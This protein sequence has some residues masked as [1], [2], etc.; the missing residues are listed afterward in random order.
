MAS[1]DSSKEVKASLKAAR[2]AI[3]QQE[4]KEALKHCKSVLKLDRTN[5]NALLFV[6][7]CARELE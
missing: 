2:D 7:K 3:R 6:G 5:Y 1:V 4:W